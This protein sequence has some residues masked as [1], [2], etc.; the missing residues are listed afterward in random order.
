MSAQS[1]P[2]P[3]IDAGLR[4]KATQ[5]AREAHALVI[6]MGARFD[7]GDRSALFALERA[8]QR[9]SRFEAVAVA[10]GADPDA[11]RNP[12]GERRGTPADDGGER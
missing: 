4:W 5:L 12:A 1:I 10:F 3:E 8:K 2:F 6:E 9:R 11:V 7:A